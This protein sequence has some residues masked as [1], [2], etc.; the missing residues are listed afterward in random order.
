MMNG[1]HV[2]FEKNGLAI[3]R[4]APLI[5]T[6]DKVFGL[7]SAAVVKKKLEVVGEEKVKQPIEANRPDHNDEGDEGEKEEEEEEEEEREEDKKSATEATP[8]AARKH[9]KRRRGKR[10]GRP[11]SVVGSPDYVGAV[12]AAKSFKWKDDP[13]QPNYVVFQQRFQKHVRGAQEGKPLVH[14]AHDF[15]F[16]ERASLNRRCSGVSVVP[17]RL[18]ARRAEAVGGHDKTGHEFERQRS[19]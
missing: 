10:K 11:Q 2:A 4:V 17:A 9:K 15:P 5:S 6:M 16:L 19:E 1:C 3:Q 7:F 12:T 18:A 14:C 8:A 13:V